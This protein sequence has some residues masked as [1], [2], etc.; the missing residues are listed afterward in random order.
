MAISGRAKKDKDV[1]K[2]TVIAFCCVLTIYLLVSTL[3]MGVMPLSDLAEL[4][5][6]ALAGVMEHAVGPW[7]ATLINAGVVL[8][9]V[10]AMLGYTV[11]SSECPYEAAAQGSFVKAFARVNKKGAPSSRWSSR[12]SSSRSSSSSCCSPTARTS[13]STRCPPA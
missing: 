13:S 3:S 7:G 6:P 8:S 12:T 10:G 1:G 9:L 4:S 2:A 11:L 5:N